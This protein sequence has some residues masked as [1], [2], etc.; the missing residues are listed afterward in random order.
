MDKQYVIMFNDFPEEVCKEGVTFE[1]A[2]QRAAQIKEAY[3][4]RNGAS[5]RR[6]MLHVRAV[7]CDV[8]QP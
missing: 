3:I 4:K 7:E 6:P 8:W 1:Q 5:A 2:N